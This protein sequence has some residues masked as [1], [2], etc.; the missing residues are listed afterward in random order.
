MEL[1]AVYTGDSENF[2]IFQIVDDN[3]V[4]SLYIARKEE[5]IPEALEVNL[6]TPTRDD[7]LWRTKVK[8]LVDKAREGSKALKKLH[9]ILDKHAIKK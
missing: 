5:N 8:V 3:V 9:A 7:H 1:I 6:I 2:H 4:G